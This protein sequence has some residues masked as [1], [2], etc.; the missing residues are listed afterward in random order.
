[1]AD[2]PDKVKLKTGPAGRL[3]KILP[4]RE[5]HDITTRVGSSYGGNHSLQWIEEPRNLLVVTKR[6]DEEVNEK[7][8]GLVSH[9]NQAYPSMNIVIEAHNASALQDQEYKNLVILPSTSTSSPTSASPLSSKIDLILTLGGDGTILHASS[10]FSHSPVPPVLSFS[11]GTLGFLLP[12]HIDSM[13][14]A[15]RDVLGGKVTLLLRMRLSLSTHEG[16]GSLVAAEGGKGGRPSCEVHLMNEVT[17]HRGS[18]PHMTTIDAY[19][20][21]EHLTRAI[22]DGL[23]IASPTG[24]TAYSLSAGGSIVHPSV[25]SLLLTPICPRSLSFRPL[26]LPS[27]TTVQLRVS[28]QSRSPAEITVDGRTG[29]LK[30][31]QYLQVSMSPYPIPCVNRSLP[32]ER[33]ENEGKGKKTAIPDIPTGSGGSGTTD[34]GEDDWV[35]DINR[36]L[37]FNASF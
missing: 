23:I 22:S 15:L 8:R 17:L 3:S 36:L 4:A 35:R 28:P 27:D 11:M 33:W 5:S 37:R 14:E 16:D 2:L 12:W 25:Q 18:Q 21:G 6:C 1:L 31:G 29:M 24:S 7:L 26:V 30:P 32:K 13:K 10:L 9:V 19:V 20:D 34:R